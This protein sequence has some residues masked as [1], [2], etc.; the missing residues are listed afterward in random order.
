MVQRAL[1]WT[2][3]TLRNTT[4]L[5]DNEPGYALVLETLGDYERQLKARGDGP[6]LRIALDRLAAAAFAYA[7]APGN[8]T[9]QKQAVLKLAHDAENERQRQLGTTDVNAM[10]AFF[11]GFDEQTEPQLHKRLA[12]VPRGTS[13]PVV[14]R[15]SGRVDKAREFGED[16]VVTVVGTFKSFLRFERAGEVMFAEAASCREADYVGNDAELFPRDPRPDD[17]R[18]GKLGDCFLLAPAASIAAHDPG[19]IRKMMRENHDGSVTVRFFDVRGGPGSKTFVPLFVN[20]KKS[21]VRAGTRDLFAQ[22]ALWV[23]MIEKAFAS[24][25]LGSS[26]S[27]QRRPSSSYG[28]LEGGSSADAL[29]ILLGREVQRRRLGSGRIEGEATSEMARLADARMPWSSE[30]LQRI[31]AA[32][33]GQGPWKASV[34]FD[35]LGT[36]DLTKEWATYLDR[37]KGALDDFFFDQQKLLRDRSGRQFEEVVTIEALDRHFERDGLSDTI[38]WRIV[39]YLAN[40]Q[41]FPGQ[42]GSGRYT[43]DQLELYDELARAVAA[44][45]PITAD[46]PEIISV[47]QTN[48]GAS[49]DEPTGSGLVGRHAYSVVDVRQLAGMRYVVVRNPWGRYGRTYEPGSMG[50][51]PEPVQDGDGVSML[52]LSDFDKRFKSVSW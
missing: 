44:G 51:E 22:G 33:Q 52:D 10:G 28:N 40:H 39:R 30:E 1:A 43:S 37:R 42:I 49:A 48:S 5:S 46:T 25:K 18:Q 32:A 50:L 17:V 16:I 4:G 20:V 14:D 47:N 2:Q 15:D 12:V 31:A 9:A 7:R 19:A 34:S 36:E 8:Q 38:R 3:Q 13:C 35:A 6:H 29:E 26:G 27:G 24:S 45:K 23:K 11:R 41:L 21:E